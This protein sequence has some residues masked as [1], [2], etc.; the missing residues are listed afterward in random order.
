MNE[1][2]IILT[3]RNSANPEK[4]LLKA[5]EIAKEIISQRQNDEGTKLALPRS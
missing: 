3:I 1:T 4:A 2:E 5:I